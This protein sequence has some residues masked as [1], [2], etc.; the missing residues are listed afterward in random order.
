MIG[1][2]AFARINGCGGSVA[3]V[4]CASRNGHIGQGSPGSEGDAADTGI[5]PR[6]SWS[7]PSKDGA[8]VA[9]GSLHK[10]TVCLRQQPLPAGQR[11]S[12]LFLQ[13]SL[14]PQ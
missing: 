12:D 5:T 13:G 9:D 6:Q 14:H 7:V 3:V 1:Y 2:A 4:P 11:F 8:S 10:D